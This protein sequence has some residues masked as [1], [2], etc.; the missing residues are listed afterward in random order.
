MIVVLG[1]KHAFMMVSHILA[2]RSAK[3]ARRV[4]PFPYQYQQRP[5]V[6]CATYR[7]YILP[8][9]AAIIYFHNFA[10]THQPSQEKL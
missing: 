3:V 9:E 2:E 6:L 5:M 10:T 8:A 4:S 1:R 7:N